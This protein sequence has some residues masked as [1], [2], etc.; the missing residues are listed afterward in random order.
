MMKLFCGQMI[1]LHVLS[2]KSIVI[3]FEVNIQMLK[4]LHSFAQ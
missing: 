1:L 3:M 4:N 2:Q